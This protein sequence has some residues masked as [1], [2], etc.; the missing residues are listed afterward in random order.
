MGDTKR[1]PVSQQPEEVKMSGRQGVAA[2]MRPIVL[3]TAG[4]LG[5]CAP[6]WP[7]G[8][9]ARGAPDPIQA[10]AIVGSEGKGMYAGAGI[11][12]GNAPIFAAR[13][14][15][16]PAGVKPLTVDI[17]NTHDFYVDQSLWLDPRYY[18]CNSP[19]GLEQ[20]WGAYEV[21][22][23]GNDPPRTAAWGYCDRDYPRARIVSPYAFKTAKAHYTALQTQARR[24]GGPAVRTQANLPDWSGQYL[25]DKSKTATWYYG[26][27]LQIPTYLSLLT[28]EYQKR[29]VQQMYH[30]SG[31]NAPQWPGS[32]CWP[33][34]FMRRFAQYGGTQI[35]L[36]LTP[37]LVLDMRNAA[38]TLVSQIHMNS[39]FD[40]SGLV[41]RLGADVPQ[42]FG[43]SIGFWDG[44]ALIS[45]TSNIQG[46]ISHG[47]AEFS[48]KLQSIEI[49]T[50]R[51]NAAG[52]LIGIKH[53]TVLY[54]EDAFVEPVRIMQTWN[55]AGRLNEHEPMTMMECIPQI[56]PDRGKATPKTPGATFDFTLLDMYGR[57]WAQIWE[58]Y[59][60]QGMQ[61]PVEA[62]LFSFPTNAD[63]GNK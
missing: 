11:P 58:R 47:G 24:H 32:Y 41:P 49:Y 2:R 55:R 50:P 43:E 23:I 35:N 12:P 29:F 3:V 33:E 20:I 40:E 16:I 18:R 8:V 21:P 31:D 46:W 34:G 51:K 30:Y 36:V 62:D 57:P 45:W 9:P 7:Q 5:F 28:P 13:D 42:W 39:R 6:S 44:E 1:Y 38:K 10:A 15:A 63:Q 61:R 14:G 25:R 37:D 22:L 56:F 4:L 60:E 19:V 17:F 26:A 54:D 52:K 53:E 59:H 27:V 48:N